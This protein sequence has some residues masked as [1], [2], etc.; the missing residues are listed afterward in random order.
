MG[1][2][3]EFWYRY[4]FKPNHLTICGLLIVFYGIYF[5]SLGYECAGFFTIIFGLS[6]DRLD[7]EFARH[8]NNVTELGKILDRLTDKIKF[9]TLIIFGI[10]FGCF[11]VNE[12]FFLIGFSIVIFAFLSLI[13]ESWG[14]LLIAYQRFFEPNT[15]GKGAAWVG[16]VKFALQAIF[17]ATLF[18]PRYAPEYLLYVKPIILLALIVISTPL[19]IFSFYY[20]VKHL[21]MFKFCSLS[22]PIVTGIFYSF[23]LCVIQ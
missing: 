21:K 19:A 13:I 15:K 6:L 20:H 2:V 23:Y 18:L 8:V 16:K 10:I 17:V 4:G 9:I 1:K 11:Q 5:F 12:D 7:G 22:L 3:Y 14:I